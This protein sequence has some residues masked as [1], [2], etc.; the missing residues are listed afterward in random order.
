MKPGFKKWNNKNQLKKLLEN[1]FDN[2]RLVIQG[3]EPNLQMHNRMYDAAKYLSKRNNIKFED[4]LKIVD[5][6]DKFSR[7]LQR[8]FERDFPETKVVSF[9]SIVDSIEPFLG[10]THELDPQEA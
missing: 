8:N 3:Q 2:A 1:A 5:K 6:V 4:I 9:H 7:S 10:E